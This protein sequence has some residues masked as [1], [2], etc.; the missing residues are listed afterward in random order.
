MGQGLVPQGFHNIAEAMSHQ[1]LE[2]LLAGIKSSIDANLS[3][4]PPHGDFVPAY[5]TG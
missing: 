5:T 4:M 3:R 2:E 1:Q